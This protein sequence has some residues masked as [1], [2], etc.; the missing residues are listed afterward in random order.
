MK[1]A[2][3]ESSCLNARV[4]A[5]PAMGGT[6]MFQVKVACRGRSN[7]VYKSKEDFKSVVQMFQLVAAM[8]RRA[9]T[10]CAACASVIGASTT[11]DRLCDEDALNVFLLSALEQLRT[12]GPDAITAC[13]AHRGVVQILMD[14]LSVRDGRYFCDA[15]EKLRAEEPVADDEDAEHPIMRCSLNRTLSQQFGAR[16]SIC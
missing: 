4:S 8:G 5:A 15:H 3:V 10:P 13:A 2:A 9:P 6:K 12:A 11:L 7:S 14:F 16:D 1:A